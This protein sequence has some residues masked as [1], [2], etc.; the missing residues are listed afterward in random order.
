MN[1]R[2]VFFLAAAGLWAC[3]HTSLTRAHVVEDSLPAWF[4]RAAVWRALLA[5]VDTRLEAGQIKAEEVGWLKANL[6]YAWGQEEVGLPKA[7]Q[8]QAQAVLEKLAVALHNPQE[9]LLWPLWPVELSSPFGYR[10]HPLTGRR[11]FHQ[12][13]DL[14]ATAREEVKSIQTGW[15]LHAQWAGGYGHMVEVLHPGGS[16]S[17]YAH[18]S[19]VKVKVGQRVQAGTVVGLAGDSGQATGVHLH[20]E[21][22]KEGRPV[23]PTLHL[24]WVP[25]LW[26]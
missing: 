17:R 22:W 11:R 9:A 15:V 19:Q 23:D 2:A 26:P 12:G 16:F 13:V 8:V 14:K 21:L 7:L 10:T 4:Q 1:M 25:T 5:E 18:L 6:V 3:G 24:P 20:F